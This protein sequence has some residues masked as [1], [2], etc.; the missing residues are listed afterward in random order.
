MKKIL[1]LCIALTAVVFSLQAQPPGGGDPE[2]MRARMKERIKPMMVQ[3]AGVTET[4]A[5]KVIDI[6]F[7]AQLKSRGL[8]MDQSLSDEDRQKKMKEINADRD[9]KLKAIP[10]TDEKLKAVNTFYEELR[11][12]MPQRSGAQGQGGGR[13]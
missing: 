1:S 3:Q 7:D 11:K 6:Y 4:E 13:Q 2:A 12:N 9:V 8:R 10:L 5:D